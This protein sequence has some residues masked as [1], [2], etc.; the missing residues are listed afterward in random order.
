MERRTLSQVG[1]VFQIPFRPTLSPTLYFR[2]AAAAAAV[3]IIALYLRRA[4][5]AIQ[6]YLESH[7]C[8]VKPQES[9]KFYLKE[10]EHTQFIFYSRTF[11]SPPCETWRDTTLF[12][13]C[14]G[15]HESVFAR[16][17]ESTCRASHL[18]ERRFLR[19]KQIIPYIPDA[20]LLVAV[21][22]RASSTGKRR[23]VARPVRG[24]KERRAME[25]RLRYAR[26]INSGGAILGEIKFRNGSEE[27]RPAG[28]GNDGSILV[29]GLFST[30][31]PANRARNVSLIGFLLH[32]DYRV[33][34]LRPNT[35]ATRALVRIEDRWL[36]VLCTEILDKMN[37]W[38]HYYDSMR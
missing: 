3:L 10:R 29:A 2:S 14:H 38:W 28:D 37:S 19:P 9:M 6:K 25:R 22:D 12:R 30:W 15:T 5:I 16:A 20:R 11:F 23:R 8:A 4:S 34:D 24:V 27:A 21:G 35:D 18:R 1:K 32:R 36:L 7:W 13:T 33:R 26:A 31:P 17:I